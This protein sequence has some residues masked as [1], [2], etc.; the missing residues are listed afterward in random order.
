MGMPSCFWIANAMPPLAGESANNEAGRHLMSPLI[1]SPLSVTKILE[2]ADRHHVRTGRWPTPNSG[3][4]LDSVEDEW[5]SAISIA[6]R[7][8]HRRLPG[9]SSLVKLLV[10][11]RGLRHPSHA[12]RLTVKQI[13]QWARQHHQRTGR[14]PNQN[15]GPVHGV[16]GET[17]YA[18]C[19][20]LKQKG[21]GLRVK[22]SIANLLR[23][24]VGRMPHLRKKHLTLARIKRWG[25]AYRKRHGRWPAPS[26]EPVEQDP[27]E[28]WL[29]IEQALRQGYRGLPGGLSLAALFGRRPRQKKSSLDL[30][31][32]LKWA[33]A[34]YCRRGR[35][36]PINAGPIQGQKELTWRAVDAA[37]RQGHRGLNG[38]TSLYQLLKDRRPPRR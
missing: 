31:R 23:R 17:W 38:G 4:V 21:R 25:N 12:P 14:W 34:Y 29:K 3:R 1:K 27:S 8:G 20:A 6:L 28:N 10:E 33:D 18:V 7:Q 30:A 26:D 22:T 13:V 11:R 35:W 19:A 5:W 15:S 37:L 32:I 16:P 24:Y 9:G 36:P 2:W